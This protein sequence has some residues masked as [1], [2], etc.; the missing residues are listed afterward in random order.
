MRRKGRDKFDGVTLT[1]ATNFTL[2]IIMMQSHE[3]KQQRWLDGR[4]R[5]VSERGRGD[6]NGAMGGGIEEE[7]C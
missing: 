6:R 4:D 7:R 1:P 3:L 2:Q 5:G